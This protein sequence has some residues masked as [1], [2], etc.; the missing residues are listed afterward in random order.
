MSR[1]LGVFGCSVA[2]VVVLAADAAGAE[3]ACVGVDLFEGV[4]E[5]FGVGVGEVS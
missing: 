2:W 4:G 3:W 5:G 1:H